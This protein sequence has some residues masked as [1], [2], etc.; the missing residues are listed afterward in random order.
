VAARLAYPSRVLEEKLAALRESYRRTLPQQLDALR[1]KLAGA[2]SGGAD[3]LAEAARLAHRLKGTA[4]S[5]GFDAVAAELEGVEAILE[6]GRAGG[7][8]ATSD[9]D[10]LDLALARAQASLG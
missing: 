4:G 2:L 9:R 10:A 5:Y 8:L 6:R 7:A 3:A 1:V